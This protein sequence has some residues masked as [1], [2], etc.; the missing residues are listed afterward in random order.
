[1]KIQTEQNNNRKKE[2]KCSINHEDS[3]PKMEQ[4]GVEG[5]FARSITKNKLRYTEYYG[6]GDT[7]SFSAVKDFYEGVTVLKKEC[8]GHVQKRV[9]SRLRKLKKQTKGLGTQGLNDACIDRLQNYYGI[10]V[11]SNVG[12]LANMK[13]SIYAALM[14]VAS[15]K[16]N[17]YHWAYCP[18]GDNSWCSFQRDEGGNK[19]M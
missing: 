5:I 8:I 16:E 4:S 14:H 10:A 18:A 11:R 3:A 12:N 2:H 13:K 9:G 15:S 19:N 1:M 6:D 17:N 7:K